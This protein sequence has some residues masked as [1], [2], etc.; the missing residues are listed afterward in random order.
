MDA[1]EELK[2]IV[3]SSDAI[4]QRTI[5]SLIP[6]IITQKDLISQDIPPREFVLGHWMPKD[7]FGMV[8]APRGVG[9]SWFCMALG[10]SIA[11][12]QKIFLGWEIHDKYSVLYVDGEMAKVELKERFNELTDAP[13]D[14]LF[15]L[16]SE[17][18][19]RDGCPICLD[20]PDEQQ[21][22]NDLLD[23]L[24]T[25]GQ[26]AQVI[27]LDNLSTLRRGINE[28]DNNEAQAL[29]DWLVSLRHK[30]YTVIVVH[31]SGKSGSQRGASIIEVPMD[32]V[33]KL[34]TPDKKSI[35][36]HEGAH[37]EF[38]FDKVRG[39]T[40]KPNK[41]LLSLR[42]N[43]EGLLQLCSDQSDNIVDRHYILLK[44]LGEFGSLTHRE[45][46]KKLDI[47][48]GSVNND[49]KK[50]RDEGLLENRKDKK[51]LTREGQRWL[52]ELWPQKFP[53]LQKELDF[54]QNEE[55]PF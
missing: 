40:P 51:I 12:G 14:N 21:A 32:Y 2:K 19:Y 33:I 34:S 13:L 36:L 35:P 47:S 17:M 11:K 20:I 43:S 39:K 5:R 1:A 22:V 37:F 54:V 55:Y 44:L 23:H 41:G 46:S 53:E 15:I 9:K 7:S 45:V 50:L 27:I 30:G 49:L 26:K 3:A 24:E 29:L 48:I 52:F 28:N 4:N 8:Y 6:Y 25:K 16:S 18:L 31:N 42:T 38:S 10:V